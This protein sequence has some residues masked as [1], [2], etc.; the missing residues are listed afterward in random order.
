MVRVARFQARIT[1][2]GK[3]K[4]AI[5][6]RFKSNT[7]R[8]MVQY[9][10][11]PGHWFASPEAQLDRAMRWAERNRTRLL[12]RAQPRFRVYADGFFSPAGAWVARMQAKHRT[13]DAKYLRD[14]DGVVKNYLLPM[15]GDD[16]PK[17][18]TGR[19]IDDRIIKAHSYRDGA[20]L[21]P[22][23][24]RRI[25]TTLRIILDDLEA[26]RIIDHNPLA[27]VA[28]FSAAPIHP[29]SA[30]PREALDLLYPPTHGELVRVWGSPMW[31]SL[32]CFLNDSG[33]R[34]G[35]ARA[36]TWGEIDSGQRF[37]AI[38]HGIRSG[39]TDDVK[40]TKTNI[41]RPAFMSERTRQELAIWHAQT[42]HPALEDFVFSSKP[43]GRPVC[44]SAVS[45]A[46]KRALRSIGIDGSEWSPYWLRHSFGTY[47]LAMLSDAELRLLMG[48][49][50]IVTSAIY[51]HPDNELVLQR[52]IG[53][54]DKLDEA[55]ERKA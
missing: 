42:R 40:S 22:G 14:R 6:Y 21:A 39:T 25:V 10:E 48:H 2:M 31:A 45:I 43:H 3:A 20:D 26:Q 8:Y 38:R 9:I 47:S 35:E 28:P 33:C 49:S 41:V 46:F 51:Q 23:T 27:S 16:V 17:E 18:L 54:R 34:P 13:Y 52:S 5:K 37:V 4:K 29:R 55:R 30:I 15:F 50:S 11:H 12:E 24:K 53:I 44:E 36:L 7:G 32:F 1:A 19:Y